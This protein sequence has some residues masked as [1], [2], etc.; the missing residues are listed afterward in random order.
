MQETGGVDS[1]TNAISDIY[2]DNFGEGIYTGK[3]I[4]DLDI[5]YKVMKDKISE[6]SVLSHDLLEGCILR[7]ALSSDIMLLD[8]YPST[9][10]AYMT[11][12]ERWI[13]RR[14]TDFTMA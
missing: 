10:S 13:R 11:R 5:F 2:Q 4:Y 1:Y 14:Y 3:G 6:N 7:C 8:G 12:L 9:F